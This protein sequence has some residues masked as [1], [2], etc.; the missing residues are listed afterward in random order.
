MQMH[1]IKNNKVRNSNKV[2]LI[3][4]LQTLKCKYEQTPI[5]K[6]LVRMMTGCDE[7]MQMQQYRTVNSPICDEMHTC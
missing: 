3:A 7:P 5:Y 4:W 6:M 1:T 2:G